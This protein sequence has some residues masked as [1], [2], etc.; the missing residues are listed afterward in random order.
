MVVVR[1][2]A[3]AS[4]GANA[5][6]CKMPRVCICDGCVLQLDRRRKPEP[7]GSDGSFI[8]CHRVCSSFCVQHRKCMCTCMNFKHKLLGSCM[9]SR[10][11]R[12]WGNESKDDGGGDDDDGTRYSPPNVRRGY[13]R[14][15]MGI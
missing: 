5:M 10:S 14:M 12:V 13:R 15:S 8:P 4:G 1:C 11:C 7:D 2:I 6:R 3:R 9:C